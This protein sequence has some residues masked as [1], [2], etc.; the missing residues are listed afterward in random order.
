MSDN[1]GIDPSGLER[2]NK[3]G[4]ATFVKQMIGL[5]LDE[6][7]HRLRAA[8]RGE[9]TGN[10]AAVAEA[11][12]SLKSS[13]HNFGARNL[14]R[15]A[16]KIELQMRENSCENLS[17]LLSDLEAAFSTLKVWLETERDVLKQ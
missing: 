6:A 9:Q 1:A 16:E 2:L 5:F 17:A 15:V 7:P 8:R 11:A 12:H 4:G 13:A 14:S 10:L 3:I